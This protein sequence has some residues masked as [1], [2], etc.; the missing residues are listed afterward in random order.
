MRAQ[1][2]GILRLATPASL[3]PDPG[4]QAQAVAELSERYRLEACGPGVVPKGVIANV[5]AQGAPPEDAAID[6]SAPAR[7]LGSPRSR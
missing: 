2:I 1:R 5:I 3:W 7:S 6:L 4:R